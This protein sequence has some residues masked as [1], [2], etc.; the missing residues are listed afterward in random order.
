[1][2]ILV[3]DKRALHWS[4]RGESSGI[5]VAH[6]FTPARVLGAKTGFGPLGLW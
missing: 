3:E 1:V 4:W 6:T 5:I 2:P